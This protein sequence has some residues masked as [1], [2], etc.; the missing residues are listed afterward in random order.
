[1]PVNRSSTAGI[2]V[3]TLTTLFIGVTAAIVL[4]VAGLVLGAYFA[5]TAATTAG[6]GYFA[7]LALGAAG[8]IGGLALGRLSKPVAIWSAIVA[9]LV[10]GG[11]T[12]G[13]GVTV[14]FLARTFKKATAN[15]PRFLKNIFKGGKAKPSFDAATGKDKMNDNTPAPGASVKPLQP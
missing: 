15:R 9:G 13:A 10:T 14:G 8:G 1:M 2:G 3:G 5:A 6:M 4:P 11:L 12:K 7:A